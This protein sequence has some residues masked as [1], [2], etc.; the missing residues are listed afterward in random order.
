MSLR[1]AKQ[2]NVEKLFEELEF[3]DIELRSLYM[4]NDKVNRAQTQNEQRIQREILG[5]KKSLV[6]ERSLKL[7]AFQKLDELKT[8]VYDM[9]DEVAQAAAVASRLT[10]PHTSTAA[11]IKAKFSHLTD[12][13]ATATTHLFALERVS[14]S[15]RY[16]SPFPK[17]DNHAAGNPA[18]R[19]IHNVNNINNNNNNN[20]N[21]NHLNIIRSKSVRELSG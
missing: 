14:N 17:L 6:Q 4:L 7:N 1:W 9:E 11:T 3:K 16:S 2:S 5:L 20:N 10:R 21:H 8:H 19:S 13:T 12:A 18:S 15:N